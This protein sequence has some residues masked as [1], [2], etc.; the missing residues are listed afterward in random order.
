M[1]NDKDANPSPTT[2]MCVACDD[3]AVAPTRM[4][5]DDCTCVACETNRSFH[6]LLRTPSRETPTISSASTSASSR[7]GS[8]GNGKSR[9]TPKASTRRLGTVNCNIDTAADRN[10]EHSVSRDGRDQAQ[11][12]TLL[13]SRGN[14]DGRPPS[15]GSMDAL[16]KERHFRRT[17]AELS[18]TSQLDWRS[19]AC[20]PVRCMHSEVLQEQVQQANRRR[21]SSPQRTSVM[22]N[23]PDWNFNFA[24]PVSS[25]EVGATERGNSPSASRA[26]LQSPGMRSTIATGAAQASGTR[27]YSG[28]PSRRAHSPQSRPEWNFEIGTPLNSD[29]Y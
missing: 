1:G 21:V 4:H 29:R 27:S 24:E 13:R 2:R 5:G 28:Y 26:R 20:R 18:S 19:Q 3:T 9:L 6:E 15:F 14:T 8:R 23:R 10:S 11:R 22:L 17:E 25:A 16:G 7:E 12:A